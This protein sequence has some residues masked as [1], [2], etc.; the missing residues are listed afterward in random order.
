VDNDGYSDPEIAELYE[1]LN[2]WGVSD[3]FYLEWVISAQSVLDVGCGTGLILRTARERGHT[4][5]LVGLDPAAAMLHVGQR[6]R[7]D[8]EWIHGD[9]STVSFDQEFDLVFMSGHAFQVFVDDDHVRQTLSAVRSALT[10]D[11]RRFRDPQP[12][13]ASLGAV[14]AGEL[15]GGSAP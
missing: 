4:G 3:D 2:P 13:S 8:I 1:L 12:G 6:D 7:T 10:S 5:R 15:G 14:D 9:L 11:G